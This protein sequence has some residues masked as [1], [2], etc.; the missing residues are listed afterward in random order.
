MNLTLTTMAWRV[1][2]PPCGK[3]VLLFMCSIA[4]EK[5]KLS[6][7]VPGIARRC[8][9]CEKT[10]YNHIA[11]L[12]GHGIISGNREPGHKTKYQIDAR[13]FQEFLLKG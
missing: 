6:E 7:S 10:T 4:D 2:L 8:N 3:L 1:N 9:L 12:E 13:R 11:I 5:G